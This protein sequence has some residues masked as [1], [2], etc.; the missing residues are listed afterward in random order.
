MLA[1]RG[2]PRLFSTCAQHP[3]PSVFVG[4]LIL[5]Y[6]MTL[7]S[8]DV[9]YRGEQAQLEEDKDMSEPYVDDVELIMNPDAFREHFDR[10][11]RYP[12]MSMEE[13]AASCNWPD[14]SKVNFQFA[15]GQSSYGTDTNWTVEARPQKELD[16]QRE[17]WHKFIKHDLLKWKDYKHKFSGRGI[18]I[19]GGRKPKRVNVLL[20]TLKNV[21]S[22]MPVELHYWKDEVDEEKKKM[23]REVYPNIYFNDLSA[24]SNIIQT[25]YG[26]GGSHYNLKTAAMVNS[27]FD[28]PLQLDSDN[29][30]I[31]APDSLWE[32]DVY[33]KH[34]SIFW[35]DI[36]RTRPN[37]PVWSITNTKC[38]MDEYEM[39]SGQVLVDKKKL[40]YHLQLAAFI[41]HPVL[42]NGKYHESYYFDFLLG[43]KDTFRF[44]WHALKTKFGKPAKAVTS[45]G[46]QSGDDGFYC[47]HSFLQYHPD[48]RPLFM[49]GGLL[50]TMQKPIMKWQREQKGGIYQAYKKSDYEE[51]HDK[52]IN[53]A[54][55]WDAM[56]YFPYKEQVNNDE[57]VWCLFMPDVKARPLEELVPGFNK[58]FEAVGGYWTIESEGETNKQVEQTEA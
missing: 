23:F 9:S 50:K 31:I 1:P 5:L 41:N 8:N 40:W 46:T 10:V 42:K 37:N 6:L 54:L 17:I 15:K 57:P 51:D 39:E 11:I 48:G 24:S 52:L 27:R 22:Q 18:V 36:A 38:R 2:F 32:S 26:Q 55:G 45:V 3:I 30:P 19:V 28:E 34:G 43:D 44:A 35:P 33:K 53:V 13:A 7:W 58:A 49:H 16:E 20:R 47:G 12:G 14:E 25:M 4:A 21:G 29:I 56:A